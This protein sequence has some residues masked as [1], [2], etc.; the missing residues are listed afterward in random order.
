M[1]MHAM[2]SY[3]VYGKQKSGEEYNSVDDKSYLSNGSG[4]YLQDLA[5]FTDRTS[6]SLGPDYTVYIFQAI[7]DPDKKRI[8]ICQTISKLERTYIQVIH[9][10]KQ[11]YGFYVPWGS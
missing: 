3:E 4:N 8:Q 10:Q 7:R 9:D 6:Q 1:M 2:Q 5:T 11:I